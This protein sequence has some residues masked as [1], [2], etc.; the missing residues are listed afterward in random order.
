MF[1]PGLSPA[2]P[3]AARGPEFAL[4]GVGLPMNS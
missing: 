1:Q 4:I 2:P 3:I